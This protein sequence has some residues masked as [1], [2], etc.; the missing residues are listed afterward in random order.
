[1]YSKEVKISVSGIIVFKKFSSISIIVN[2]LNSIFRPHI[3]FTESE[4]V[5]PGSVLTRRIGDS[6]QC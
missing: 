3:R 5:A 1:M 2:L 4:F 6:D